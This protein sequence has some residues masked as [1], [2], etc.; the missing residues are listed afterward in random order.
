MQEVLGSNESLDTVSF[1]EF[2]SLSSVPPKEM[3]G[4]HLI[5]PKS[6]SSNS[7]FFD[8]PTIRLDIM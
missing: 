5:K 2:L 4:Y 1:T 6:L 8:Q 3:S 7:L